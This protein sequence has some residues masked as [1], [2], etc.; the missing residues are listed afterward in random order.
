MLDPGS[1]PARKVFGLASS[2]SGLGLEKGKEVGLDW[3]SCNF[4][5]PWLNQR[6]DRLD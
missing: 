4:D 3:R 5:F 2:H 1:S 6:P